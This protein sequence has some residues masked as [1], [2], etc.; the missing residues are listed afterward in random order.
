MPEEKK[1]EDAKEEEQQPVTL[2]GWMMSPNNNL[3]ST[4]PIAMFIIF[5]TGFIL[6]LMSRRKKSLKSNSVTSSD[7]SP[8]PTSSIKQYSARRF[9]C[10]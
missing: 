3:R 5:V 6:F 1:R 7:A 8:L 4:V 10:V 9:N 2:M